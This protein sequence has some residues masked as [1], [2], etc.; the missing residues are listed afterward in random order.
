MAKITD[1]SGSSNVWLGS[2]YN[3]KQ[4]I[5]YLPASS[6]AGSG[7]ADKPGLLFL[8]AVDSTG[9]M[10][11]GLYL[12]ADSADA[13][14]VSATYPTNED[15]AASVYA[16]GATAALLA[17]VAADNV[18]I[19]GDGGVRGVQATT[20]T[21]ADT[22]MNTSGMGTLGCGTI[23]IAN[24]GSL[25]L[26][27]DITFTGA[28]GVNL[29]N[30]PDN[31]ATAL[32]FQEDTGNVSYLKFT[33]TNSGEKV[34]FGKLF[35]APT[36]SKIG[37]LTLANGSITDSSNAIDFG[38]E[39]LSTSGTL[40]CGAITS[41]AIGA[42]GAI[43]A[44]TSIAATTTVTAGTNIISTAGYISLADDQQLRLGGSGAA[45][46][47]V[48]YSSTNNKLEFFDRNVN[49]VYSLGQL[50]AGTPLNPIVTGDLT[51]SDGQF[52]W[53]STGTADVN[54]WDF[55]A[56]TVDTFDIVSDN[57]TAAFLDIEADS[58]T[59]HATAAEGLIDI[60]VDG[61][62]GGNVI[63]I[64]TNQAGT[65]TGSYLKFYTDGS[66]DA[67]TVKGYGATTIAGVN[68][69]T[70]AL[71]LTAGDL[72]ITDGF[73]NA[74]LANL[75][76]VGH[77]FATAGTATADTPLM[78][79]TNSQAAFDQPLLQLTGAS[80][81]DIN[82]MQITNAGTGYGIS[83]TMSIAAG[84]GIE[85]I[86]ATGGTHNGIF[87]DG[88][89]GTYVGADTYGMLKIQQTGTLVHA[90]AS[91]IF[92]DFDGVPAANALGYC[93][94]IDDES[95][96]I[97]T[98][99][100]VSVNSLANIPMK[101]ETQAVGVNTLILEACAAGI[102][103][104]LNVDGTTNDWD[105]A[106]DVGM[107]HIKSDTALIHANATNLEVNHAT[108]QPITGAMGH[109]AR[110]VSTGTAQ[111]NAYGV[112]IS[113][114]T[115][116]GALKVDAGH[117]TFDESL[118]IG[119]T[120]G[121]TGAATFTAGQQSAAVARTA[122]ADG[123]GDGTIADGTTYVTTTCDSAAKWFILPTPTPGNVL[124][125]GPNATGHELRSSTPAS[126]A[127]NGGTGAT[128]ESAVAANVTVRLVCTSATTW[129][130][131]TF[132]ANG[133]EAALEAAA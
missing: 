124:W 57:T 31:L 22:T 100:A 21:I 74:D 70:A 55:G 75:A 11:A 65:F 86:F 17:A 77:N 129:V 15:D 130:G 80:S 122:T 113:C 13:L 34:V 117:V 18:L 29:I 59:A 14:H 112:Y 9:T 125:M 6:V 5:L 8:E 46:S 114:S 24:A 40:G 120:L 20:I 63:V 101:L 104:V 61:I 91:A 69:T 27:E 76:G 123:T 28:T 37:N 132:A 131:T 41:G 12:W 79:L 94:N 4:T 47:Y 43:T 71:T 109:L 62:V 50:V 115:T 1:T 72:V 90:N 67:F 78:T 81:G 39:A 25:N 102:V 89:T 83:E 23:T 87:I 26:E 30:F 68:A 19:R 32:D 66:T 133:T 82:T 16:A 38:N 49:A 52:D 45:D 51:I 7:T 95:T 56:T 54:T 96:V 121:V 119:T 73:I 126:V 107:V 116:Q 110:F 42:T 97:S 48:R 128:A 105:G 44:T 36:A 98:A 108:A 84:E 103:P 88:A 99:V 33:T 111:T 58:F 64:D 53:V 3:T 118:T 35:E 127:I 2:K 93:L 10:Q 106:T 92:V 85:L 60:N